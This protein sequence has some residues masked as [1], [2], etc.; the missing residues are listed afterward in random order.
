MLFQDDA[1]YSADLWKAVGRQKDYTDKLFK[2][3]KEAGNDALVGPGFPLPAPDPKYHGPIM[4][5]HI[6]YILFQ[7]FH[8]LTISA[9]S[10]YYGYSNM[11]DMPTG[12]VPVTFENEE[13]QQK[14]DAYPETDYVMKIIK[15]VV[16]S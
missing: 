11:C 4:R 6:S 5:N 2:M 14:L 16:I 13:D 9:A 8:D 15:E 1:A 7:I 12:N 3:W 10:I